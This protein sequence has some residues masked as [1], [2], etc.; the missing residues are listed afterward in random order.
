MRRQ[1][2]GEELAALYH[3]VGACIWHIQY[4]EDVLHTFLTIKIEIKEPGRVEKNEATALLDKHRRATLG[5][6]IR[7]AE[8]AKALPQELIDQ[9]R[10]LKNERDWLVHRSMHQNGDGLY[11]DHGREAVFSR[12]A[13][14]QE[15]T[16]FLKSQIM[17]EA[18][19]YCS[20]HGLSA[21]ANAL[22]ERKIAELR[23]EG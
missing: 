20:G 15:K 4:L 21:Q 3:D 5:N 9:L 6:A 14:L 23:G 2:T 18:E 7:T 12:L 16:I 8:S 13:A 10:A 17:S 19:A 22:A 1:I 11:T